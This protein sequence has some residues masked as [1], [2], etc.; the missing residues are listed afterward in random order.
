MAEHYD[1]D[2]LPPAH[3]VPGGPLP[4]VD[5]DRVPYVATQ[6]PPGYQPP[7]RGGV[8]AT[9]VVVGAIVLVLMALGIAGVLR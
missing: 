7:H 9:I 8:V 1:G 2:P 3:P 5:G 4:L 6:L